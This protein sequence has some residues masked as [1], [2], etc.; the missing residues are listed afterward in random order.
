MKATE[1]FIK[2]VSDYLINPEKDKADIAQLITDEIN[3]SDTLTELF[4]E[5]DDELP[6]KVSLANK[7]MDD[8]ELDIIYRAQRKADGIIELYDVEKQT[9]E[10]K[11]S[12]TQFP[13]KE[14]AR[15]F[16]DCY[17]QVQGM[18]LRVENQMRAI[19]QEKDNNQPVSDTDE[20]GKKK[21]KTKVLSEN[22]TFMGYIL[23]SMRTI[24]DSIKCGLEEFTDSAFIGKWCKEVIGIGPVIST[25]LMAGIDLKDT[26]DG[27]DTMYHAANLWS[28]CGLNDNRR[29]WLGRTKATNIVNECIEANGGK[30][31]DDVVMQIAGKAVWQY[32]DLQK[33]A[34]NEKKQKWSKEDIIKTISKIPYN[35]D[36][37]VLMFKIS[38]S[39]LKCINKEDSLYGNLLTKRRNYEIIKNERGDYAE[40][41][42]LALATKNFKKKEVIKT[43]KSGKLPAGHIL[44][45]SKRY[46]VKMFMS[47]FYEAMYF[48]KYG[49]L[50]ANPYILEFGGHHDYI[51][52]EVNYLAFDRDPEYEKINPTDPNL[53][54]QI[55]AAKA[56][57]AAK[58]AAIAEA[59]A[60]KAKKKKKN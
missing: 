9:K 43:Y 40:Q 25:C 4:G 53:A 44:N 51:A 24:E 20:S 57:L 41:A 46:A 31:T 12:V 48:N 15:F 3:N 29:P 39:F 30:L 38:E 18:R 6:Q 14:E 42:E 60:A 58:R 37:K 17:Y 13:G 32:S 21:K 5:A 54:D 19:L 49:R 11:K 10:L 22:T 50:P 34:Y 47:H 26:P 56:E 55:A 35:A 52:P 2:K 16:A 28:Y 8:K 59:K 45:R 36:L 23:R 7:P 33:K 27:K 1:D